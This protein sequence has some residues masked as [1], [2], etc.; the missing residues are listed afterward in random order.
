MTPRE[1]ALLN[2]FHVVSKDPAIRAVFESERYAEIHTKF[3]AC[4]SEDLP[5]VARHALG[6]M[7]SM[8]S[9]PA[10]L[11]ARGL[12]ESA[13]SELPEGLRRHAAEAVEELVAGG[14]KWLGGAIAG[15]GKGRPAVP[16]TRRR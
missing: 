11:A 15:A 2:Y 1:L 4:V 10:T 7:V 3:L 5:A 9:A 6:R 16:A 8:A 14:F 13:L 12:A